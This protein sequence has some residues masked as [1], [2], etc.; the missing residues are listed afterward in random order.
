MSKNRAVVLVHDRDRSLGYRNIGTLVPELRDRGY[1]L[2]IHSFDYGHAEVPPELGGAAMVVVMGSP[3]AAYEEI[4]WIGPESAYLQ[5]A[6]ELDVPILGICFG[7]QLLAQ[8]LGG[9]VAKSQ[10]PE[11]GFTEVET[12]TPETV[13]A[14]PWM[15]F[16][17]D[18][19]LAPEG[20]TVLARNDAGQQAFSYGPHL[21][22][23]FH[24]EIDVDCFESWADAWIRDG[25]AQD[26][27]LVARIRADLEAG[28]ADARA[29]CS[30]LLDAWISA[31][32]RRVVP[33]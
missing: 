32:T 20:A 23:Q 28:E 18:T 24:P 5:V 7:G 21:G 29:R 10:F 16:H 4:S 27:E 31:I 14:G 6:I 33:T 1:E 15:E 25:V 19:F 12:E 9:T 30:D 22:L 11:Y 3:D 8:V 17:E 2:E 26:D 13:G